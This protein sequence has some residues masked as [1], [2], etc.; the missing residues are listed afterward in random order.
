MAKV[1]FVML[2][3]LTYNDKSKVPRDVK[4]QVFDDLFRLA[5]GYHIAG[6]GKGA[7]R[8]KSGTKKV[9][10]SLEVWV[11][12]EEED[13]AALRD[14]VAGFAVLLGQEAIYLEKVSS[15][16]EFVLPKAGEKHEVEGTE[17]P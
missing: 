11:A 3:P 10:R 13:Q 7:Y 17:T 14:M 6:I 9:D 1:K 16:V 15:T 4:K 5:G 12:V 8:M 2:L